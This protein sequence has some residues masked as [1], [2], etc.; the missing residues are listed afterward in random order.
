MAPFETVYTPPVLPSSD[1]ANTLRP[2]T[3]QLHLTSR[4]LQ[5]ERD[6]RFRSR[7]SGTTDDG[8]SSSPGGSINRLASLFLASPTKHKRPELLKGR[9]GS[10][11]DVLLW[12]RHQGG[13][14]LDVHPA[15]KGSDASL[16]LGSTGVRFSGSTNGSRRP[17][18]PSASSQGGIGESPQ[19]RS[20]SA[21][22]YSTGSTR[23]THSS[24]PPQALHSA[25]PST[26]TSVPAQLSALGHDK[27]FPRPRSASLTRTQSN[28]SS[29]AAS[30]DY[31]RT[32]GQTPILY[33]RSD[34]KGKAKEG[35]VE[36]EGPWDAGLPAL[37]PEV[38]SIR[39]TPMPPM[40][41]PRFTFPMRRSGAIGSGSGSG[42]GGSRGPVGL[43]FGSNMGEQRWS[44]RTDDGEEGRRS[45]ETSFVASLGARPLLDD[46]GQALPLYP[47][48]PSSPS[49]PALSP[50]SPFSPTSPVPSS[51]PETPHIS[52]FLPNFP[53]PFKSTSASKSPSKSKTKRR[54]TFS[55]RRARKPSSIHGSPPRRSGSGGRRRSTA[56][57]GSAS[58]TR[59]HCRS[60]S[61]PDLRAASVPIDGNGR[62]PSV[63]IP[64]DMFE[65]RSPY[66]RPGRRSTE[67]AE[68]RPDHPPPAIFP[69]KRVRARTE[70]AP[71][72]TRLSGAHSR[73]IVSPPRTSSRGRTE[74]RNVV[75]SGVC[76]AFTFPH[77]RVVIS[78]SPESGVA[79]EEFDDGAVD[80]VRR[81]TK[82][83]G[84]VLSDPGEGPLNDEELEQMID[85]GDRSSVRRVLRE[86]EESRRER[87][88]WSDS[89][90]KTL[91]FGLGLKL[92]DLER[93]KRLGAQREL[94]EGRRKARKD[95]ERRKRHAAQDSETEGEGALS[96][97]LRVPDYSPPTPYSFEPF[98][99][100][101]RKL[102]LS[103]SRDRRRPSTSDGTNDGK[104]I[105]GAL[106]RKRSASE[107]RRLSTAPSVDTPEVSTT[108]RT[109]GGRPIRHL[110]ASNSV[111]SLYARANVTTSSPVVPPPAARVL[112]FHDDSA[113]QY[114]QAVTAPVDDMS[115]VNV[116]TRRPSITTQNAF[117][118]LPPHLHHL[119]RSPERIKYTPS[120]APPPIPTLAPTSISPA[121]S[122]D[123]DRLSAD[124]TASA[125]R[126]SLALADQLQ[127]RERAKKQ[128]MT[129]PVS[130]SSPLLWRLSRAEADEVGLK[131][132]VQ[133]VRSASTP[134]FLSAIARPSALSTPTRRLLRGVSGSQSTNGDPA[135]QQQPG[136]SPP[137]LHPN[138]SPSS[139]HARSLSSG[140][141]VYNMDNDSNWKDLFFHPPRRADGQLLERNA[142]VTSSSPPSSASPQSNSSPTLRRRSGLVSSPGELED[143]RVSTASHRIEDD[144]QQEVFDAEEYKARRARTTQKSLEALFAAPA[145][146]SS[147]EEGAP[148]PRL[149]GVR[150]ISLDTRPSTSQSTAY[151]TAEEGAEPSDLDAH[152]L[153]EI[154]VEPISSPSNPPARP[155]PTPVQQHWSTTS[156][157]REYLDMS[158]TEDVLQADTSS[159][160]A[161]HPSSEIGSSPPQV[162]IPSFSIDDPSPSAESSSQQLPPTRTVPAPVLKRSV[163][164]GSGGS[165]S[166]L[167]VSDDEPA[168]PTVAS[169]ASFMDDFSPPSSAPNSPTIPVFPSGLV[170][171]ASPSLPT[172]PRSF[173][174]F[175]EAS[176]GCHVSHLSVDSRHFRLSPTAAVAGSHSPYSNSNSNSSAQS[177]FSRLDETIGDFPAPPSL[178]EVA[179]DDAGSD[180]DDELDAE[181]EEPTEE[182]HE[183]DDATLR[184][185]TSSTKSLRQ[186]PSQSSTLSTSTSQYTVAPTTSEDDD[187][188]EGMRRAIAGIPF[189]AFSPPQPVDR[190]PSTQS[191]LDISG[192]PDRDSKRWR[193]LAIVLQ[194]TARISAFSLTA[195]PR[196]S[197]FNKP[198][199]HIVV[200][201]MGEPG[202]RKGSLKSDWT[203]RRKLT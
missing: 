160:K 176:R 44:G 167:E 54:H 117:L 81:S 125:A 23:S 114:G 107:S 164:G 178:A 82:E 183:G 33:N 52:A 49:L 62:R 202:G 158:S 162:D 76:E 100:F 25:Y 172:S 136:A 98:M 65:P 77:P 42:S 189:P 131:Q 24:L 149:L 184:L 38:S 170:H 171:S 194:R 186:R 64:F 175:E 37:A 151:A 138:D 152:D 56:S 168:R 148:L 130:A 74:S 9:S 103:R 93:R 140:S 66:T 85:L 156:F 203:R 35:D 26:S 83:K 163:S 3:S 155:L 50:P 180:G 28:T 137:L 70:S 32:P 78:G 39:R 190:S 157:A 142:V 60:A 88:A 51:S 13:A 111:D 19:A 4:Q 161:D 123:S 173:A 165:G 153:P 105:I 61:V 109:V 94:G 27:P 134:A 135:Q 106:R 199:S 195:R 91:G 40:I 144:D 30:S 11:Q 17:R 150:R 75:A 166:F 132:T 87:E 139:L 34:A 8:T 96:T 2:S 69:S 124:S 63:P 95:V 154:V 128:P 59:L 141:S 29:S 120:R 31:P 122:R 10:M 6:M 187:D 129:L 116:E 201:R 41:D 16:E 112:S 68:G 84:R 18:T 92:A 12:R 193:F 177:H 47:S 14:G 22:T 182:S 97:R 121:S 80:G 110:R 20:R 21:T 43:G 46:F 146:P 67:D 115:H 104:G 133:M 55:R 179:G 159:P 126:L 113:Q 181:D 72:N 188:D 36:M 118:S 143:R 192:S 57:A 48:I 127:L 99:N 169:P 119:L 102:S 101:G 7:S 198:P 147:D 200:P 185:R 53:S 73:R 45:G 174:T 89:A 145:T 71:A 58:S 86:N 191:F 108:P 79:S 90:T 197:S 1:S 196:A 5:Q 15:R